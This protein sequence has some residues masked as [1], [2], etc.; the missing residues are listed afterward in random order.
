MITRIPR[1]FAAVGE[2]DEVAERA[3]SRIDAVIVRNVIT[4]VLARRGLEWHQPNC[5]DAEAVQ[6]VQS[7]HQALEIA[8]AIAIGIHVG[9]DRKAIND[10]VLV[11]KVFDHGV[12]ARDGYQPVGTEP[13]PGDASFCRRLRT[14]RRCPGLKGLTLDQVNSERLRQVDHRPLVW[15]QIESARDAL[16]LAIRAGG[17]Q[18]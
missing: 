7:P 5:G 11:P 6:I 12:G 1:C 16:A 10:G 3:V 18:Q 2:F 4:I 9:T 13:V 15:S 17:Q 8:N 14:S